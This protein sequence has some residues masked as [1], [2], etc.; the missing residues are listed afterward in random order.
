MKKKGNTPKR[1]RYNRKQRL[2]VAEAWLN[3]YKGKNV[4]SSYSKWFGV[5]KLCA[6][7]ELRML[8]KEISLEYE[9]S[10]K[11]SI[12]AKSEQKQKKLKEREKDLLPVVES[13]YWFSHIVGYTAAGFPFGLTHEEMDVLEREQTRG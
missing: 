3:A 10:L 11:E 7:H 13:D 9:L 1:K 8:G 12:R 6:V 4:V 5:D 2:P